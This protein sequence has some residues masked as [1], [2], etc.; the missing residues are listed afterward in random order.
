MEHYMHYADIVTI[1]YLLG[2]VLTSM[3]YVP[4]Q[5]ARR[6]LKGLALGFTIAACFIWPIFLPMLLIWSIVKCLIIIPIVITFRFVVKSF[7]AE[8][9]I[10]KNEIDNGNKKS[11]A[12][13]IVIEIDDDNR[14][15]IPFKLDPKFMNSVSEQK[16]INFV[17]EKRK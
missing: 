17:L 11:R 5:V 13:K 12:D 7:S 16:K 2:L 14:E 15:T 3:L 10:R 8:K 6:K 4:Y 1:T 9:Q